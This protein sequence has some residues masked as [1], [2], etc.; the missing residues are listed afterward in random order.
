MDLDPFEP[1]G[2]AASTTRFIDIFL[3]HCLLADSPPDS[4]A[5]IAALGRNQHRTAEN[6]RQ[7]GLLLEQGQQEIL[8]TDWATQL[9]GDCGVIADAL[10]AAFGGTQYAQA[11]DQARAMLAQPEAL[12]SAR[13][14]D[15]MA[16][17]FAHSYP[18]F[19]R[20]QSM[21]SRAHL[22]SLPW[23]EAQAQRYGAMAQDSV[24]EQRRI[25]AADSM[26]FEPYRQAYLSPE[27]LRA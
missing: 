23:T 24:A 21:S 22:L 14:L 26:L 11:L 4:A 6:G 7:P 3:L 19:I 8:L 1:V 18:R 20:A 25:E 27:R 13:V 10:D 15:A 17:D 9:L 12:P 5:E 16:A 2:I